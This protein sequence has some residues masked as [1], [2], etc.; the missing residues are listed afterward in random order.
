[1]SF[2]IGNFDIGSFGTVP[3]PVHGLDEIE[4]PVLPPSNPV[5]YIGRSLTPTERGWG[6]GEPYCLDL[7]KS[8]DQLEAILIEG[9]SGTGK[10]F[11]LFLLFEAITLLTAEP[12]FWVDR[13]AEWYGWG[14]PKLPTEDGFEWRTLERVHDEFLYLIVSMGYRLGGSTDPLEAYIDMF[15]SF[16]SPENVTVFFPA[17]APLLKSQVE[18]FEQITG[19]HCEFFKPS[20]KLLTPSAAAALFNLNVNTQYMEVY[21]RAFIEARKDAENYSDFVSVLSDFVSKEKPS[22]DFAMLVKLLSQ[23][24][25][26]KWFDYK[27]DN[28]LV[29]AFANPGQIFVLT[30]IGMPQLPKNAA[31]VEMWIE[32]AI[33]AVRAMGRTATIAIDDLPWYRIGPMDVS[34]ALERLIHIESRMPGVGMRKIITVQTARQLPRTISPSSMCY[35]HIF[36]TKPSYGFTWKAHPQ[37]ECE[38]T[39]VQL[40]KNYRLMLRPP[41]NKKLTLPRDALPLE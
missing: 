20:W 25:C 29:R 31:W 16:F 27:G 39:Q 36:A 10:T 3:I 9:P 41:L 8:G 18:R 6:L 21:E 34:Q 38:M 15:T 23:D 11:L 30:F 28:A 40:D 26:F 37:Y 14:H 22:K 13:K 35:T 24:F 19:Y 5:T 17:F 12:I 2:D 33:R 7:K 1:V 4:K 32:S